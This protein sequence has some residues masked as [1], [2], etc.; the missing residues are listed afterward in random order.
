MQQIQ[1]HPASV[2][3]YIKQG[4][5][6]VPIPP[7]TKGPQHKGWNQ[8]GNELKEASDLHPGWGIG[9]LH[10]FSGTCAID[11]DNWTY[12][13]T[14]LAEQGIDLDQL[15]GA[16]DA[17]TIE[18]G[19]EGRGKLLYKL[20]YGIAFPSKKIH[21]KDAHNSNQVAYEL[22]CGTVT[23]LTAQDV[24]PPSIHP[25]TMQPYQ[26]GGKGHWS[27]IPPIPKELEILWWS[28]MEQDKERKIQNDTNINASWEEIQHALGSVSPDVSRDEWVNIGMALHHAGSAT[29]QLEQALYIWN[30]WSQGGTKYQGEKDILTCWHSFTANSG[31][32]LG[33]L[34]HIAQSYG[35]TRPVPDA[36]ELFSAVNETAPPQNPINVIDGLRPPSP[37][38]DLQHW[39]DALATRA[40]EVSDQVGCDPLVPLFAGLGALAGAVDARMRLELV[41]GFEVPPIVWLMTVGDPADKKSPG[42]RPMMD[43][44]EEL[45]QED[46]PRFAQEMLQWEAK[47]IMYSESKKAYMEYMTDPASQMENDAPPVLADLESKPVPLKLTVQDVTSQKLVHLAA[48]RDRGLLCYLDEMNSWVKKM[49]NKWGAED[50]ST[51]VVGYEGKKYTMDRVGAGNIQSDNFAISIYGNIQPQVFRN[52]I[53]DLADDGLIQRFI[54]AILR[55]DQTKLGHPIPESLTSKAVWDQVIRTAYSLQHQKYTLSPAAYDR[56]REFQAWYE[57][58]KRDERIV[59]SDKAYRTAFGKLEGTAGRL[60][61][62]FHIIENPYSTQVDVSIVDK[63]IAVIKTYIIPAYRYT[64]GE[65]GGYTDDSMDVW[66]TNH[67]IHTAGHQETISLSQIKRSARRKLENLRPWQ[68]EE[69]IRLSMS[70]LQENGWVMLVE[71]KATSGHVVWSINPQLVEGFE[72]YRNEVIKAKQRTKDLIYHAGLEKGKGDRNNRPLVKG[73]DPETMDDP[74]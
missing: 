8:W 5:K 27:R 60:I 59:Q 11:I 28:L 68:I 34:F 42:S 30:E 9:L 73:Y 47:E 36:S 20:P 71:D 7:G 15:Y 64:L 12:A 2:E 62:L 1:S 31:I 3:A 26:W 52:N 17:V 56:F 74:E 66:L 29:N 48:E 37:D 14:L 54:P 49:T 39:P 25:V 10:S 19:R 33:T 22:R 51:W 24:L 4:L 53:N 58:A 46:R 55:S 41:P 16:D 40:Q 57:G 72:E 23:G 6:L 35:W 69:Q 61:L 13:K 63:V 67:V 65:I 18:S 70:M 38:L 32:G 44:L 43:I 21:Y 50:R 45:E